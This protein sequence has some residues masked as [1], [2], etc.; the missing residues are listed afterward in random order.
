M[1]KI[2]SLKIREYSLLISLRFH[3]YYL[4]SF[5]QTVEMYNQEEIEMKL[6]GKQEAF[7]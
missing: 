7:V 2:L 5:F 4:L 6:A 1:T 3:F